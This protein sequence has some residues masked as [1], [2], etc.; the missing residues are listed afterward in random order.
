MVDA[1]R[2]VFFGTPQFAVPS[3]EQLIQS[4][5]DVVGVVTQPD[6][7]RGRGQKVTDAPVKMTAVATRT[8][9]VSTSAAA[10]SRGQRDAHTL[11]T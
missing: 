4:A 6:R 9:G 5:H 1:M 7:P 11:G 10:R 2:V 3:L 8:P